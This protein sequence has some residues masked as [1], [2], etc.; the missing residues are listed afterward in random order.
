MQRNSLLAFGLIAATAALLAACQ[1]P[2]GPSPEATPEGGEMAAPTQKVIK[3]REVT[4]YVGPEQVDCTGVAPQKCLMVKESPEAEY[5]LFYQP[6]AGFTFEPGYEYELLVREDLVDN[7]AADASTLVYT[8]IQ[9][10]NKTAVPGSTGNE[11]APPT[12]LEGA[13]WQLASYGDA[14]SP[15]MVPADVTVTAKFAEGKVSGNAGCNSYSMNYV[16]DGDTLTT[17]PGPV[18]M[19]ACPEPIMAVEQAYLSA[20]AKAQTYAIADGQLTIFYDGGQLLFSPQAQAGL[21]GTDWLVTGYNNGKEA[22]VSVVADTE[23]TMRFAEGKL[24]GVSGCNNY[25]AP[26]TLEGS[27]L[28]IGPA[29]STRKMC[30]GEGVMEQEQQFLAALTTVATWEIAADQVTLRTA[31]GA[32]AVTA[33]GAIVTQ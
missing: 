21:E 27:N 15:T 29:A 4:L 23:I 19:M 13:T 2:A 31:D 18:T 14:A 6:I 33:K 9:E 10:V 28:T 16:V 1:A 5:Q 24:S 32:M 3:T 26:Y 25:N 30:P 8:L 11:T 17:T 7:P 12:T 20:M 22:V